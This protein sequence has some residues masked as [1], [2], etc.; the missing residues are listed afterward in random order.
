MAEKNIKTIIK[1]KYD[2]LANWKTNNPVLLK[3]EVALVEVPNAEDPIKNAPSIIYKV[4]DGINN[5]NDLNFGAALSADVYTWAKSA[6]K[7]TYTAGEVG[8]N[9]TV[10]PGLKKTGTIT[11]IKMNGASKGTSGVVDLG[12]VI[13]A[14][15]DISGKQNVAIAVD[16]IT[17]KTVENALKEL[18]TNISNKYTKPTAGIP[19]ADLD[20]S[21]KESLGKADTALQASALNTYAT[22]T[23]A[24]TI[25]DGKV[26]T[27][28]TSSTA[29]TDIRNK[30]SA[31]EDQIGGLG[32]ALHFVGIGALENRPQVAASKQGDVYLVNEGEKSGT[33]YIFNGTAWEEFGSGEHIT[34]TQA[35]AK[36]T[37]AIQKLNATITGMGA[38]KTLKT[39]AEA[40]GKIS[41]TF[42]DISVTSTQVSGLGKF[43]TVSTL[44][45]ADIPTLTAAK[46]SDFTTKATDVVKAETAALNTTV[47]NASSGLVKD[48]AD[49]KTKVAAGIYYETIE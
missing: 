23:E 13:T 28:N 43:A 3:G 19:K 18:A 21:V 25:A 44:S 17:A 9:E 1:L 46:I 11:G 38:G 8:V 47:G 33:E 12:T 31:L 48:V 2:T 16:G 45:V 14:H 24:G 4:G 7:P 34:G 6:T 37:T 32:N 39:L 27:H 5:F 35:D 26:N 29:H 15:Q 10:F 49:L 42:Q 41:A 22:K 20:A 40:D 36:I 30:I